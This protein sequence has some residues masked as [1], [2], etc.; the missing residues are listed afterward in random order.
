MEK[1]II[2]TTDYKNSLKVHILS[3]NKKWFKFYTVFWFEYSIVYRDIILY[4]Q[5]YHLPHVIF[6]LLLLQTVLPRLEFA[7]RELCLNML[8]RDSLSQC[9]SSSLKFA[10][11]QGGRKGQIFPCTQNVYQQHR[12]QYIRESVKKICIYSNQ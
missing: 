9:N 5:G 1:Q 4:K 3:I 11:R 7:Q 2:R 10:H 12:F 6:A 8:K